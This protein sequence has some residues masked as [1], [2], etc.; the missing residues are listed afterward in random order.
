MK[1][2]RLLVS[3]GRTFDD[4]VE[5]D[6]VLS[7]IHARWGIAYLIQG[8]APGADTLAK[9]WAH[10]KRIPVSDEFEANWSLLG[11]N[12]GRAR[13]QRM[14]DEGKPDFAVCFPGGEGTRDMM[15]R[16]ISRAPFMWAKAHPVIAMGVPV[17]P[18]YQWTLM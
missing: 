16:L 14:L 6:R 1:D 13:N 5:L 4:A 12:A 3:G 8:E 11:G 15:Q 17:R 2:I 9:G 7:S 18:I 10:S